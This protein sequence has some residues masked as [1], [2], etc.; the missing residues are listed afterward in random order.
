MNYGNR[1][2][3]NQWQWEK[4]SAEWR[5]G[6]NLIKNRFGYTYTLPFLPLHPLLT[7]S[8]KSIVG[9]KKSCKKWCFI[10]GKKSHPIWVLA[11]TTLLTLFICLENGKEGIR[12]NS[13]SWKIPKWQRVSL[14]SRIWIP[15][16]QHHIFVT[17]GKWESSKVCVSWHHWFYS[18]LIWIWEV[19][20]SFLKYY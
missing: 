15:H 16:H 19:P 7:I 20:K 14:C 13:E 11:V 4:G 9:W 18:L 1:Y 12:L 3:F 17:W 6:Q 5:Y 2:K 8:C 10:I